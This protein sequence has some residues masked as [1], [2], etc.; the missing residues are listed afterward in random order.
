MGLSGLKVNWGRSALITLML[1]IGVCAAI[2][3]TS[4]GNGVREEITDEL[5]DLG[6]NQLWVTPINPE[7]QSTLTLEDVRLVKDLPAVDT[8]SASISVDDALADG[9]TL[10]PLIGVDASYELIRSVDLVDGSHFVKQAGQIVLDD[11]TAKAL[12]KETNPENAVGK[13]VR[14]KDES[15]EVVGVTKAE[16]ATFGGLTAT[17]QT[18][19]VVME[20][21]QALSGKKNVEE[22]LAKAT[23]ASSMSEAEEEIEAALMS[24]HDDTKDFDIGTQEDLKSAFDDITADLTVLLRGILSISLLLVSIGVMG[25][26][27]ASVSERTQEI[28]LRKA[29]GAT[30]AEVL[31][32]FL[33]E[34]LTLTSIGGII[35]IGIGWGVSELLPVIFPNIPTDVT[36]TSIVLA[37]GVAALV[38][39][40]SGTWPAIRAMRLEPVEALRSER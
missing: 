30:D 25:M 33:F 18:S 40:V 28:G 14:I 15:Y 17:P 7:A 31:L 38:G 36:G 5:D 32:Q 29:V 26:L 34:A 9:E 39:L 24:A 11:P 37:F 4:L 20:D 35:G 2:V 19:F 3:L 1:T 22:I 8:A 23:D 12:L 10:V 21:A 16:E 6:T 13:T 27:F